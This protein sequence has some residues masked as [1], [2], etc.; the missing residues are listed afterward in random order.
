MHDFNKRRIHLLISATALC[1]ALGAAILVPAG[2]AAG[3]HVHDM[4]GLWL[5]FLQ[6]GDDPVELIRTEITA[7]ENRRFTGQTDAGGPHVIDGTVSASGNVNYQGRGA[8]SRIV[9]Q[10]GLVDFGGGASVLHGTHVVQADGRFVVPCVL[11]LRAFETSPPDRVV[12]DPAGRYVGTVGGEGVSGEIDFV[13]QEPPDPIRPTSFGG[14]M[15][16]TIDG[17]THQFALIGTIN[18]DGR[19]ILIGHKATA[20]HSILDA[21]LTSPPD[22]VQPAT[23]NGAIEV[24]FPDGTERTL[25][26]ETV[27]TRIVLGDN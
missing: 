15:E 7:Q 27:R 12:P 2:A 24:E 25:A 11:E 3:P 20:G 18:G 23:L 14:T 17:E 4:R 19:V 10:A 8:D 6:A 26:F 21:V 5:G 13:L 22:P 9:G 1:I 16:I